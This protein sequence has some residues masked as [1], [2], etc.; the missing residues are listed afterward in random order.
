MKKYTFTAKLIPMIRGGVAVEF[1]FD[2]QKEFGTKGRVKVKAKIDNAR[3]RSSIFPMKGKHLLGVTKEIRNKIGK[4]IGDEV[5]IDL[6]EDTEPRVV[7]VP[8]D[9]EKL[10]KKDK[11][12]WD[13]FSK[14]AYTH[15]KEY[16]RWIVEAKKTETRDRRL[17]KAFEMIKEGKKFS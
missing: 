10:L 1:P 3:Y 17:K 4:E 14:F 9:F 13:T 6:I 11:S 16:V 2:V 7:E 15:K 5:K 8:E 12:V